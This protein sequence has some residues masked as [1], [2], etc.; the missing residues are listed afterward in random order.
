MRTARLL[1]LPFLLAFN[2]CARAGTQP[3]QPDAERVAPGGQGG[4]GSLAEGSAEGSAPT[5]AVRPELEPRSLAALRAEALASFSDWEPSRAQVT[6]W[7]R[8]LARVNAEGSGDPASACEA[9]SA[10]DCLVAGALA[11]SSSADA[12]EQ[13]LERW[14]RGCAL[15]STRSCEWLGGM[16]AT[17]GQPAM[18]ERWLG[19]GC[20]AGQPA[21]CAAVAWA[22]WGRS[23]SAV[24]DAIAPLRAACDLGYLQGC[25]ALGE[26][27]QVGGDPTSAVDAWTRGCEGGHGPS[28]TR[29][30]MAI[31]GGGGDGIATLERGCNAGEPTGCLLAALRHIESDPGDAPS[32][33]VGTLLRLGC[34]ADS[35]ACCELLAER[36]WFGNDDLS[37][38]MVVAT[39]WYITACGMGSGAACERM[40]TILSATIDGI[41]PALIT[42]LRQRA[43]TAGITTQCDA[44]PASPP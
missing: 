44:A 37:E 7:T 12:I 43:C 6:S 1:W 36:L 20:E 9:G 15:G 18:A 23:E 5:P 35:V 2:A 38:A 42:D 28:C 39:P 27:L 31:E 33:P 14:A 22:G 21:A 4:S 10:D 13:M 29:W 11:A 32:E 34:E 40:A 25:R 3:P 30:G 19:P 8:D 17:S 24:G 16:L 41:D 26:V